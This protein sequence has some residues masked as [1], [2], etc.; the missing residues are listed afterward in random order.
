M[1]IYGVFQGFP[2][3]PEKKY[4]KIVQEV[5]VHIMTPRFL[6]REETNGKDN[7]QVI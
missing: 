2:D 6:G 7:L 3:F 4:E 1:Q 5:W